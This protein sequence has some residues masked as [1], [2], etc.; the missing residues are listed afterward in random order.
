M[1]LLKKNICELNM[2]TW[3][4]ESLP[5]PDL[6]NSLGQDFIKVY[7]PWIYRKH[8]TVSYSKAIKQL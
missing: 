1:Q 5:V 2:A 3:E 7:E 6:N 4:F 8:A